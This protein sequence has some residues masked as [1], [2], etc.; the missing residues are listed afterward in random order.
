[1]IAYYN[2]IDP[3]AAAWLE[4]LIREGHISFGIVDTRSIEDVYPDDLKGFD[5]CHFFAGV[6]VWDYALGLA[7][8]PEDRPVW[9]GSCPCQPFST[10]GKG[11][12]FADERHLWPAWHHLIRECRP[13]VVLGEQAADK[14]G[15]LWLDLVQTDLEA[16]DYAVGPVVLPAA[17]VGAPHGRH[18]TW[19]VANSEL[20]G[21]SRQR[22]HGRNGATPQRLRG[23]LAARG[24][25]GVVAHADAAGRLA[26]PEREL[27]HQEHHV[28]P[29][30]GMGDTGEQRLSHAE[31][32]SLF[33]AG[34]RG[35]GAAVEQ[36]SR[37]FWSGA[38]WL[39]CRDRRYRPVEPG[40]FP[41]VASAPARM[42]RLRAYGNALCAQA[43]EAFID[44]VL[45]CEP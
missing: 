27:H 15:A 43:A 22:E 34:R 16:D 32:E 9:T 45:Q 12:G 36:P 26:Q 7:G 11:R 41:L 24:E 6:G 40:T 30:S 25:H 20:S 29:R 10:A 42:G 2:E 35:E 1:M 28:E 33:G 19:F 5:R 23:G 38:D 21:A 44:A 8:W 39:W 17:G 31:F 4:N 37:T 13:P 18:R 14:G 3:Y